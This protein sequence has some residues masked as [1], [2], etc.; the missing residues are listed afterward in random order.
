MHV[1]PR[2]VAVAAIMLSPIESL[3]FCLSSAEILR[4]LQRQR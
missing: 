3:Y 1:A 2:L 4:F